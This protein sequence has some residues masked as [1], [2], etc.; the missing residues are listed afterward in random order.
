MSEKNGKVCCNCRHNI[1]TLNCTD[2]SVKLNCEI[3][4]HYIGYNE[5]MTGWCRR[6]STDSYFKKYRCK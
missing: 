3:D 4:G 6:W 5:C 2:W 1:R